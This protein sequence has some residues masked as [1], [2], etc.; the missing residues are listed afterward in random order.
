MS[1]YLILPFNQILWAAE[2]VEHGDD[3]LLIMQDL[4]DKRIFPVAFKNEVGMQKYLD[5]IISES[6]VKHLTTVHILYEDFNV[7]S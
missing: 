4:E 2:A 1:N 6:K 3:Y 7:N 5:N